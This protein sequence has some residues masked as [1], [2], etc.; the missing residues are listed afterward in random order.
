MALYFDKQIEH[1]NMHCG[2]NKSFYCFKAHSRVRSPYL[3]Q[4]FKIYTCP[5]ATVKQTC[6]LLVGTTWWMVRRHFHQSGPSH[7]LVF[8]LI[9]L[10]IFREDALVLIK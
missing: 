7:K 5:N 10:D 4:G 3:P 9:C 2:L 6:T 8:A 1:T